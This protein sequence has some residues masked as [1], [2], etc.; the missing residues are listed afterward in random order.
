MD[1]TRCLGNVIS[2]LADQSIPV[3]YISDSQSMRAPLKP[4]TAAVFVRPL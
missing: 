2:A 3:V 4:A 1:E